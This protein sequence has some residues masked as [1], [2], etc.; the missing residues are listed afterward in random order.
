MLLCSANSKSTIIV[1]GAK[2]GCIP[3]IASNILLYVVLAL[4]GNSANT[5]STL[6]PESEYLI[7][8]YQGVLGLK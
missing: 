8:Y 7:L 2:L 4:S 1:S 6:H 5:T 3:F